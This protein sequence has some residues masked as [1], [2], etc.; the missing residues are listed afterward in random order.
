MFEQKFVAGWGEM[1]VNCHMRNSAFLDTCSN[2]RLLYFAANGF[3]ADEFARRSIGPVVMHDDI[4]YEAEIRLLEEITV[5]LALAGL[6]DDGS[7]FTLRNEFR[8]SDGKLAA[9]VTSTGGWLDLARRRLTT[10][11]AELLRPLREL[12]RTDDFRVLSSSLT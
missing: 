2:V 6:S 9:S 11:P 10:P 3:P 5:T 7:R 12:T 4:R 1:D 8:K